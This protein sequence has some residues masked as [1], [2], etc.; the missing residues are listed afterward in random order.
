VG[1]QLI[2]LCVG[3]ETLDDVINW[4]RRRAF[5]YKGQQ[6]V[7]HITRNFPKRADELLDGGSLYWVVKGRIVAR[8]P[9]LGFEDAVTER[10]KPGCAFILGVPLTATEP[11]AHRPFQGWRYLDGERAP[12]DLPPGMDANDIPEELLAELKDLGLV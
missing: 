10:G 5:D 3:A 4:H 8:N 2:K 12:A 7:Q 9:I 11:R 6:A 1:V